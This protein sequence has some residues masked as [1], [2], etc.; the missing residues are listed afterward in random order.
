ME[1][2]SLSCTQVWEQIVAGRSVG[3]RSPDL[4][5]NRKSLGGVDQCLGEKVFDETD[6]VDTIGC[7]PTILL[8]NL[9]MGMTCFVED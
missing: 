7:T 9:S 3:S 6:S 2:A 1:E 4:P 5:A 8:M